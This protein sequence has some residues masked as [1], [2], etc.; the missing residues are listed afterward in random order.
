MRT[1]S[2]ATATLVIATFKAVELAIGG[3]E[4][5]LGHQS[6]KVCRG[7]VAEGT[8]KSAGAHGCCERSGPFFKLRKVFGGVLR[9]CPG[10][11]KARA[12]VI[13]NDIVFMALRRGPPRPSRRAIRKM[14]T[15]KERIFGF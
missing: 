10:I 12:I 11:R 7:R 8:G 13:A 2:K 14:P 9:G 15:E 5:S 3:A 1:V 6:R 4:T